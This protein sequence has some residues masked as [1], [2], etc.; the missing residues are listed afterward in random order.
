MKNLFYYVP[1][2]L[3]IVVIILMKESMLKWVLL[4]VLAISVVISKYK[5]TKQQSDDVEYDERVNTNIRYWSF[6][7]LAITNVLLIIYLLL[8]SQ[9]FISEWMT[10]EFMMI[11]LSVSLLISFYIIPSVVKKF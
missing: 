5:R 3:T 1:S 2:L 10:I 6:G 9:S 7:F 4:S 8:V 11:Y